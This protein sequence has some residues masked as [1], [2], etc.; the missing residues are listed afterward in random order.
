MSRFQMEKMGTRMVVGVI[1][2]E[3]MEIGGAVGAWY[4]FRDKAYALELAA[5]QFTNQAAA[6]AVTGVVFPLIASGLGLDNAMKRAGGG[7]QNNGNNQKAGLSKRDVARIAD[8]V[9]AKPKG[10]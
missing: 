1:N 5:Y 7:R 8:A 4:T 3:S 2:A 6:A 10:K 9:R